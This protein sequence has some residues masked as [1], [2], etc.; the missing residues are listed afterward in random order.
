MVETARVLE[1]RDVQARTG[2]ARST[3]YKMI[4]ES[5]FPSPIRLGSPRTVGWL[6]SEIDA[7]IDDQIRITRG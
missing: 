4:Q 1:C 7:W 6:S 5:R 2:L 3:L